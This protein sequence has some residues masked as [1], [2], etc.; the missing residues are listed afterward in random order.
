MLGFCVTSNRINKLITTNIL[1]AVSGVHCLAGDLSGI[2][3]VVCYTL[4]FN[5]KIM[6]SNICRGAVK[7][8]TML[9]TFA[10]LF[11]GYL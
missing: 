10:T 11:G 9:A 5:L 1:L 2:V 7:I 4:W 8:N 3:L 6:L